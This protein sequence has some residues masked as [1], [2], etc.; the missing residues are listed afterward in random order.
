MA[1]EQKDLEGALF[2]N[3]R[4]TSDKHPQ[5]K[6]KAM[7]AGVMYWV[8]AWT[9]SPRGGGNRFQAL[10]FERMKEQPARAEEEEILPPTRESADVDPNDIPF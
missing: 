10:K 3:E 9:K 8:S 4:A 6:G 7:I 5:M 1:F 2:K